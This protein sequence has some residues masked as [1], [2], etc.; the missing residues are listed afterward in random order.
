LNVIDETTTLKHQRSFN[1]FA[2]R[3]QIYFIKSIEPS[4]SK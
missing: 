1:N 2:H 3:L 4:W